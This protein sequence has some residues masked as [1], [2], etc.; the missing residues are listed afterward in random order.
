MTTALDIVTLALE[1]CG[2]LGIGQTATAE[3]SNRGLR[4]LNMMLGQW[5]RKRWLVYHLIDTSF[6][7]TGAVSY[8]VGTGGNFSIARPDRLEAAYVRLLNNAAP[9]QVDY[10]L[11]ILESME[12][13]SRIAMKQLASLPQYVFYDSGYATGTL[14]PW[15]LPSNQYQL[16]ILTKSVLTTFAALA[17][18]VNLPP[19]YEE[20]LWTNLA[21]RMFPI[22]QIPADPVV[23][24]LATASLNTIRGANTQ[25]PRLVMPTALRARGGGWYNILSDQSN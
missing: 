19:E 24:G 12:D 20:A 18:T 10:P 4:L 23:V 6:T 16:H 1:A 3:D 7:A 5:N 21:I 13:Y 11:S 22:Y 15:P 8:T 25:I 9:N 2:N 17:T 14:Y